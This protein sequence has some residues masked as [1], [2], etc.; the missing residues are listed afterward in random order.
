MSPPSAPASAGQASAA[1]AQ[2]AAELREVARALREKAEFAVA[3]VRDEA[4]RAAIVQDS[5]KP[6]PTTEPGRLLRRA[7]HASARAEAEARKEAERAEKARERARREEERRAERAKKE[8]ELA[9]EKARKEADRLAERAKKEAELAAEKARKEEEKAKKEADRLA[10]KARKEAELAEEKARKEAERLAEKARKEA[11]L[12]AEKARKEEEKAKKE[13]DRLAEKARKED[14]KEKARLAREA[15]LAEARA[16]REAASDAERAEKEAERRKRE[17]A[18]AETESALAGDLVRFLL[19]HPRLNKEAATNAFVETKLS[20][21]ESSLPDATKAFVTKAFVRA[22]IA[23]VAAA[24]ANPADP[25]RFWKITA[26]GLAASGLTPDAAEALRP[27]VSLTAD[28]RALVEKKKREATR[29]AEEEKNEALKKKQASALKG[30]FA[31]APRKAL[32]PEPAVF[33][34]PKPEALDETAERAFIEAVRGGATGATAFA[35]SRADSARR[36]KE[37]RRRERSGAAA[38]P[39]RWGAR[40]GAKRRRAGAA[41]ADED[42]ATRLAIERSLADVETLTSRASGF[43]SFPNGGDENETRDVSNAPPVAKRRRLIS[44]DCSSEYRDEP[45][46]SQSLQYRF[47]FQLGIEQLESRADLRRTFPVPGGRPAFWGSFVPGNVPGNANAPTSR[48][49]G[50]RPF[51]RD[52]RATYADDAGVLFDSGDEWDEPEDGER[53]DGSDAD[54]EDEEGFALTNAADEHEDDEHEEGFVVP[55]GYLSAEEN[56]RGGEDDELPDDEADETEDG[57]FAPDDEMDVDGENTAAPFGTSGGAILDA[58]EKR[59]AERA[60]HARAQLTQWMDR[61]RRQNRPL[62][63]ASF[64]ESDDVSEESRPNAHMLAGLAST[65]FRRGGG[66]RSRGAPAVRMYAPP[67]SAEALAAEE[68]RRAAEERRAREAARARAAAAKAQEK[69]AREAER[70]RARLAR[71]AAAASAAAEKARREEDRLA[72]KAE[73]EREAELKRSEAE[74]KKA[75]KAAAKAARDAEKTAKAGAKKNAG[76]GVGAGANA[77]PARKPADATATEPETRVA[78][79]SPIKSL[80]ERAAAANRTNAPARS[81]PAA[82]TND[83]A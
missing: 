5:R 9:E 45:A 7:E 30:F 24:P 70:E 19:R 37:A 77:T 34:A 27:P 4:K 41:P 8:A 6:K 32:A 65:R 78:K 62:V 38:A 72:K 2:S 11:E 61:A 81:D 74:K 67:P 55:D 26:A 47:G 48:A 12:A 63:V 50:R 80:F 83:D 22:Q 43:G 42:A 10:E 1:K 51:A 20:G 75:E 57:E 35:P 39:R 28:E 25:T 13:A 23:L 18:R 76:I 31:A 79:V 40:R 17:S 68:E 71:D 52:A 58:T 66:S 14:E 56:A 15:A 33:A 64:A 54:D 59:T 53:L 82:A 69:A 16:R 36:W 29:K 21:A 60:A 46:S 3:S 44:V 49:S 73:K